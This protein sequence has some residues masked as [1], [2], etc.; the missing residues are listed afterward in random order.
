MFRG[1]SLLL[2]AAAGWADQSGFTMIKAGLPAY[3]SHGQSRFTGVAKARR[4]KRKR[5]ARK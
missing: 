4:E 3:R 1:I 5:R 2:V